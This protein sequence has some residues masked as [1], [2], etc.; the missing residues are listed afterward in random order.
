VARTRRDVGKATAGWRTVR[1]AQPELPVRLVQQSVAGLKARTRRRAAGHRAATRTTLHV[2]YRDVLH[3]EDASELGRCAEA[4]V[5][6]EA[7]KDVASLRTLQPTVVPRAPCASDGRRPMI[8]LPRHPV[9]RT[10]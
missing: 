5:H 7:V 8:R 10:G 9:F 6:G 2:L 1:D 4:R 3:S